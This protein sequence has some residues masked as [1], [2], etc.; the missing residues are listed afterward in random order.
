M[1]LLLW[2]T[3][4]STLVMIVFFL[5]FFFFGIIDRMAAWELY[6]LPDIS[7][8]QIQTHINSSSLVSYPLMPGKEENLRPQPDMKPQAL[9][10]YHHKL[11]WR[12]KC[13]AFITFS[14]WWMLRSGDETQSSRAFSLRLFREMKL[15]DVV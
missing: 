9:F 10:F 2:I 4:I 7:I 5:C 6:S 3:D 12:N 1:G 11:M 8:Q 15:A 14:K 13:P